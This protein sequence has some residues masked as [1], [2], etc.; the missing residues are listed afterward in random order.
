[1]LGAGQHTVGVRRGEEKHARAAG[2]QRNLG[3][4]RI[5]VSEIEALNTIMY[6]IVNLV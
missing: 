6:A 3:F 1:M 5:V 4:G 2:R